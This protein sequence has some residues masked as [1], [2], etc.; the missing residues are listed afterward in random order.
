MVRLVM[1]MLGAMFLNGSAFAVEPF[2]AG[3]HT[4]MI[5]TNGTRLFVRGMGLSEHLTTDFLKQ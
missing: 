5:A 3:Y 2:P 1:I 4:Q